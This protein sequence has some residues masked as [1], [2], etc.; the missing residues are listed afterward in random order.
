MPLPT[1]ATVRLRRPRA[2]RSARTSRGGCAEPWP[3]PRMPPQPSSAQLRL[4]EHR[5]PSTLGP[6]PLRGLCSATTASANSSAGAGRPGGVFTQSRASARRRRRRPAR[7]RRPAAASLASRGVGLS[8]T[9]SPAALRVVGGRTC[10]VVKRVAAEQRSPRR[11]RA[12]VLGVVGAAAPA[13]PTRR[14]ASA[15]GR[16][17]RRRGGSRR[18]S[19]A[20]AP[21][22]GRPATSSGRGDGAR[23]WAPWRPRRRLP[24][25]PSVVS[26][27]AQRAAVRRGDVL[28]AGRGLRGPWPVLRR[29][30]IT[31]TSARVFAGWPLRS[32]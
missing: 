16:A 6:R 31:T 23:R 15:R 3:T 28:A 12:P 25:T 14:S 8:T 21:R 24:V 9:T 10:S 20:A 5:R 7:P 18:R 19:R 32:V 13:R 30:P 22:R 27:G 26:S 4:V 2:R 17:C 1:S 11:P 29:T